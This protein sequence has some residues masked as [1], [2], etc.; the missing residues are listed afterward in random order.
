MP[1]HRDIFAR[2]SLPWAAAPGDPPSPHP[3]WGWTWVPHPRESWGA[4]P[5][6]IPTSGDDRDEGWG[7]TKAAGPHCPCAEVYPP[8]AYFLPVSSNP[9]GNEQPGEYWW[10]CP[11]LGRNCPSLPVPG[12]LSRR[13]RGQRQR[14]VPQGSPRLSH[15]Q[16]KLQCFM[17]YKTDFPRRE[18][19]FYQ[20][21]PLLC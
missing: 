12:L 10:K 7:E 14:R 11:G 5:A 17:T 16:C 2:G 15:V 13:G 6:R 18:Q 20:R 4:A 8:L 9:S 3:V 1:Q 19:V 21:P